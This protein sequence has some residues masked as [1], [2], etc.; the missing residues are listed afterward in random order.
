M[1]EVQEQIVVEF[2]AE[3]KIENY[4][5]KIKYCILKNEVDMSK[6]IKYNELGLHGYASGSLGSKIWDIVSSKGFN[7]YKTN[8]EKFEVEM[9]LIAVNYFISKLHDKFYE[10]DDPDFDDIYYEQTLQTLEE[11]SLFKLIQVTN[12]NFNFKLYDNEEELKIDILFSIIADNKKSILNLVENVVEDYDEFIYLNFVDTYQYEDDFELEL[13]DHLTTNEDLAEEEYVDF[14]DDEIPLHRKIMLNVIRARHFSGY[15]EEIGG[16]FF[17]N[18][19]IGYGK[20][21]EF[22]QLINK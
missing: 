16:R 4:E 2:E 6:S 13:K 10:S 1:L 8:I 15:I 14:Y 20:E 9:K 19:L 12:D 7:T 22:N 17:S 18:P 11:I 21:D 3:Q 5:S